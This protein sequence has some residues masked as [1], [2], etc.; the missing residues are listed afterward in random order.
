MEWTIIYEDG[1]EFTSED[2][3]PEEAPPEG[4]QVII[5]A[6]PIV[7]RRVLTSPLGFYWYENGEWWVCLDFMGKG[8]TDYLRKPG[9][10]VIKFGSTIGDD[11]F[12]ALHDRAVDDPRFPFKKGPIMPQPIE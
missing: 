8:F 4:V 1:S 10:K 5:D 11:E 3:T 2:G 6:N 12:R 7:G 9:Y